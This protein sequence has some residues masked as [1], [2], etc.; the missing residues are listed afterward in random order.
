MSA[1]DKVMK[2]VEI[3]KAADIKGKFT[4]KTDE[5]NSSVVDL[6]GEAGVYCSINVRTGA[7]KD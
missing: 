4:F 7:I 3:A 5:Y 6:I 1:K 2:A